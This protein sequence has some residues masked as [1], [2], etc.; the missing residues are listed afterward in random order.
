M[1]LQPLYNPLQN[2]VQPKTGQSN[3]S[4]YANEVSTLINKLQHCLGANLSSYDLI[5]ESI[6]KVISRFLIIFVIKTSIKFSYNKN[7]IILK[8]LESYVKINVK[9]TQSLPKSSPWDPVVSSK[10]F[11]FCPDWTLS[12]GKTLSTP[13]LDNRT[14][15]VVAEGCLAESRIAT[16]PSY[17]KIASGRIMFSLMISSCSD[18]SK[19]VQT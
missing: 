6:L 15:A 11:S 5:Y 14:S 1:Q 10:V 17:L 12:L 8:S 9:L 7:K 3:F 16:R 4:H 18:A 13:K 2:F 19:P